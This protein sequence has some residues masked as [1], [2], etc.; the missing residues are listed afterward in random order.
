MKASADCLRL[1][2]EF[3]GFRAKPYLCPAGVPT[4]GLGSTRYEDGRP[5]TL[6]DAPIDEARAAAI[7]M[8][9]LAKEYEPAV[10]R[11]VQVPLNQRQFDALVDF[12]YNAGAQNLRTSTL[13]KKLNA[14]DYAGA[15]A[16]FGKWV[17]AGGKALPGLVRRREAERKLF[18][19]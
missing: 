13:L 3:E 19:S 1:I 9:T 18:L 11:Y 14:G 4:I 16:E 5:V 2:R 15:G 10:A 7:V 8:A 12:A 17:M 6:K